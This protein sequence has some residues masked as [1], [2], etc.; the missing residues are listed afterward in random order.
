VTRD[1]DVFL[2]HIDRLELRIGTPWTRWRPTRGR[3]STPSRG[4]ACSFY[5]VRVRVSA[6]NARRHRPSKAASCGRSNTTRLSRLYPFLSTRSHGSCLRLPYLRGPFRLP[7]THS[8]LL[9]RRPHGSCKVW[10]AAA[11]GTSRPE[12]PHIDRRDKTRQSAIAPRASS[13]RVPK[14][15]PSPEALSDS[16][17]CQRQDVALTNFTVPHNRA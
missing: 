17:L 12:G 16:L 14:T 9:E 10:P 2:G 5:T 8:S 3:C 11:L 13:H 15:Y 1:E 7:F 6:G 4:C